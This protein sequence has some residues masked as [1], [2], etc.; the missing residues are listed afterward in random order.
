MYGYYDCVTV[1]NNTD[2]KK[3]FR[4]K[5]VKRLENSIRRKAEKHKITHVEVLV[6]I[7]ELS[8]LSYTGTKLCTKLLPIDIY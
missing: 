4:M 3:S 7:T 8:M 5:S 1:N 2:E 6:I